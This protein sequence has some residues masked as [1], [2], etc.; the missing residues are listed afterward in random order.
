MADNI[1]DNVAD[2]FVRAYYEAFD[3]DRAALKQIYVRYTFP[4]SLA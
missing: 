4:P 2:N 1:V 3:R